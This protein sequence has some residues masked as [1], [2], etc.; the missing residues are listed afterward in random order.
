MFLD[1]VNVGETCKCFFLLLFF[2]DFV[3]V[4]EG[5]RQDFLAFKRCVLLIYVISYSDCPFLSIHFIL[6][7]LYQ[8]KDSFDFKRYVLLIYVIVLVQNVFFLF[9]LF[10]FIE[11]RILCLLLIY[12]TFLIQIVILVYQDKD[13]L[14]FKRGILLMKSLL[15]RW[16][17]ILIKRRILLLLKAVV[18]LM[19]HSLLFKYPEMYIEA[20]ISWS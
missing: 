5:N 3:N 12:G 4:G 11:I 18:Y 9:I 6:F 13:T 8:Y 20:G 10:I 17:K 7:F 14:A 15:F 2:W 1:V 19:I 16:S